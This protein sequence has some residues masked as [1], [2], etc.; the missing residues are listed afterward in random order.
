M[1]NG[2]STGRL[3]SGLEILQRCELVSRDVTA[4]AQQAHN[5]PTDRAEYAKVLEVYL[6]QGNRR[7][8]QPKVKYLNLHDPVCTP[9]QGNGPCLNA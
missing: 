2:V 8:R 4:G 3:C 6:H 1:S 7:G 9:K 5:K